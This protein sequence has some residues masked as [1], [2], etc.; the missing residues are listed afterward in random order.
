[1][2]IK[3]NGQVVHVAARHITIEGQQHTLLFLGSKKVHVALPWSVAAER[4]TG[5]DDAKRQAAVEAALQSYAHQ[6]DHARHEL[7]DDMAKA[8]LAL[9]TPALVAFL[10]ENRL[11]L[12]AEYLV[13][14]GSGPIDNR[15]VHGLERPEPFA[16]ALTF[17]VLEPLDATALCVDPL[18]TITTLAPSAGAPYPVRSSTVWTTSTLPR[19]R[20]RVCLTLRA[21]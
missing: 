2:T 17:N 13:P 18:Y 1:V 15:V 11:V 6:P 20:L 16:F 12:N 4:K 9:I 21:L 5:G 7:V 14:T 10:A 8:T 3:E 19:T